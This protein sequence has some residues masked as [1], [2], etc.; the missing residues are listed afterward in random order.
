MNIPE[1]SY[2]YFEGKAFKLESLFKIYL[3]GSKTVGEVSTLH[4]DAESLQK[5][6]SDSEN[7]KLVIAAKLKENSEKA[8][9]RIIAGQ[10]SIS[11]DDNSI[12]FPLYLYS[13]ND[14][15]QRT[16]RHAKRIPNLNR[17]I[18]NEFAQLLELAFVPEKEQEGKVC[19][20]NNPE[21]RDDYKTT[22]APIDLLDYI[23]AVLHS[24]A[25]RE[26]YNDFSKTD[27]P[28]IHYPKNTETFWQLVEQ[29]KKIREIHLTKDARIKGNENLD[30]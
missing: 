21:V 2:K 8:V 20:I 18:V 6:N 29:G 7:I 27:F 22:F 4:L 25:F 26:K 12:V 24:T 30:E 13:N 14:I 28:I 15:Q 23:Y 3:N 17:K 10:K 9:V 5:T 16:G 11:T 19:Y 1:I